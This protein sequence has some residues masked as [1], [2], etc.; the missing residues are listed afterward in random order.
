MLLIGQ[1]GLVGLLIAWGALLA[2]CAAAFARLRKWDDRLAGDAALPLA[3]VV[4]LALADATL[5]AF[6]FAPAILAAGA[7]AVSP[8]GPRRQNA[9]T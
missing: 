8:M 6:F 5:N 3:I 2:A 7:I 4:L 1:Y 9:S